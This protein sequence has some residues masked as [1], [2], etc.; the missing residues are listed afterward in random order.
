MHDFT[1]LSVLLLVAKELFTFN[2]TPVLLE[3]VLSVSNVA[4]GLDQTS[5]LRLVSNKTVHNLNLL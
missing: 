1:L 5:F 2:G 4:V 3:L